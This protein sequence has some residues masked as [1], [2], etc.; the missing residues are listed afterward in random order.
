MSIKD[1]E[2]YHQK[3]GTYVIPVEVFNE[4][5]NE[6]ENWKQESQELKAI[7]EK[8]INHL[9]SIGKDELARYMQSQLFPQSGWIPQDK[10]VE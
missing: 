8:T 2:I 3:G 7:Y 6:M 1:Y 5:F 9:F 10:E 4:L